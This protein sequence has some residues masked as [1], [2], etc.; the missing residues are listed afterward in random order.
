MT[1]YGQYEG[2]GGVPGIAPSQH[3]PGTHPVPHPG[4]TPCTTV[5]AVHG[6]GMLSRRGNMV[7][8]LISV[9]QLTLVVH[10][11]GFQVMTEVYNLSKIGRINNHNDIPGTN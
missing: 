2:P 4:Y 11:S 7:V 1:K 9:H 5:T 10:F 8:G 3:P 6:L